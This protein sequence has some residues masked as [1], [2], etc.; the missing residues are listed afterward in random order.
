MPPKISLVRHAQG[1]HNLHRDYTLLDPLLTPLG[2]QQCAELSSKFPH[3]ATVDLV[4][5]SPLR[6]T[7]QTAAYSFG[8]TLARSEVPFILHPALQEVA[9]SGSDTGTDASILAK[10][11][12]DMFKGDDLGFHWGKI[13]QSLVTDG[14][15]SKKGYWAYTREALA[16][17]SA[18]IR[19]WLFQR[20]EAHV[21]I[22]T[23]GAIAHFITEDWDVE[24][25]M[26]TTA[27]AN[28]E[29]RD[30]TFSAASK[31][32]DAHLEETKESKDKRAIDLGETDPHVVAELEGAIHPGTGRFEAVEVTTQA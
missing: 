17:R 32:G 26:T 31:D 29:V 15:N 9:D 6:R 27:Y 23:H 22:V 4:I 21:I 30:F 3:H 2:K 12:E 18:D 14:W 28:C 8:P 25:P 13:D 5:A 7:V 20:P 24:D 11:Y 10:T 19:N 1:Y 16:A